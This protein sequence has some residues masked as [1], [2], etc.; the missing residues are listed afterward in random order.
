MGSYL[1]PGNKGFRESLDS[2]I[3]VD[4]TALIEKTN[5]VLNTRQKFICVSRPRRF[6]KSMA[7]DMLA[8]YYD[9]SEDSSKLFDHLAV[10]SL[11]SYRKHLNQYDVIKINMQEF[12][13]MTRS[14]DEMLSMLSKYLIF[15]LTEHFS[16]MR[17]RD[18]NNLLQVMKDIF[19]K[20]KRPFVILIDEWDCLFREYQQDQDAQKRYLD[21]LRAWLKDQEYVALAYMTGI[22]PI[23]KY[24]SHSALNMFT[25]YSMTDPGDLAEYFGFTEDEVKAL[26]ADHNMSFEETQAWYDGYRLI[27]HTETGDRCHSM[28]SP[29]SVVE[30]M[31]RHKFG[32]YWNQTETYEALKIYIQMDMDG[33]KDAIIKMLAREGVRINTGTFGNDMTT[34]TTKDDVLTL[35]THLGYLTYD[36]GHDMV[37]IPNKEVSQEYEN[38][39]SA[40]DWQEVIHSV[41]RSRKL[42]DSLLAMDSDAVAEG[43]DRAHKEISILQYNDENALSCTINLAFYFARE[44]YTIVRELPSGKGFADICLIP[45]KA[46]L[47]KPAVVIELK[48][49]KTASGA[50]RQIKER[51]YVEALKDYQGSLLLVGINYDKETKAHTCVIEKLMKE[52]EL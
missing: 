26:C 4:K 7:A 30:A 38:A 1:N 46:H 5:A 8:A 3:Y 35:L 2:S 45:R 12:L 22:L 29:K 41:E 14:I 47:D 9:R 28:Y 21:F 10:S 16:E 25:E 49:D 48:W 19:F 32:T 33:L 39:L 23:K 34:F 18:E 15:D 44:Y 40:M 6:G 27:T 17:F 50:I 11:A 51:Q 24:G 43:I 37:T 36:S 52:S 31:L 13:S 20:T 42:L